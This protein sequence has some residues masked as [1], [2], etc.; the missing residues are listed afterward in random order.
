LWYVNHPER[1]QPQGVVE[2]VK[3]HLHRGN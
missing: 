2:W 1:L 3:V